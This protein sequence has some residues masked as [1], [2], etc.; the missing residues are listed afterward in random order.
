[1]RLIGLVGALVFILTLFG[2]P[3]TRKKRKS[4]ESNGIEKKNEI[5]DY[6]SRFKIVLKD[7][8]AIGTFFTTFFQRGGIFAI[9][10]LLSFW[11]SEEFGY[12][13][14]QKA[15]ILMGS[16]I[17][18]IISNTL[19]SYIADK[20]NKRI[21]I[22]VGTGLTGISFLILPFIAKTGILFIV[23]F[24][25]ANFFGGMPMG[26][27]NAYITEILPD[28]KG[29]VVSINNS[30]GQFSQAIAVAIIVRI[31]YVQTQNYIWCGIAAF[32]LYAI[33]VI[34]MIF[35]VKKKNNQVTTS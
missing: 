9:T 20:T 26:S 13:E 15:L 34:L 3:K 17:A 32:I 19:F 12:N 16:G 1:V 14:M 35:F 11:V 21:I 28:S 25:I 30:F 5:K 2:L 29:T 4:Q 7:K 22:L 27:Y 10:V 18:A 33:S 8:Y 24:I 6:F 31:I 23:G